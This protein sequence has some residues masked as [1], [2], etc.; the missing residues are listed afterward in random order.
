MDTVYIILDDFCVSSNKIKFTF[1]LDSH[2]PK[3]KKKKNSYYF[4]ILQH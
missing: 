3:K 1:C 4:A 2:L